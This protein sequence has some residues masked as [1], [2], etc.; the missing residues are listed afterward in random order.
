MWISCS[1]GKWKNENVGHSVPNS[2]QPHGLLPTRFLC[3]RDSPGKNTGVSCHALTQGIFLNQV[4]NLHLLHLLHWQASSLPLAP[5]GSNHWPSRESLGF[6]HH[7]HC[8]MWL[9]VFAPLDFCSV[10]RLGLNVPES[11]SQSHVTRKE[12]ESRH[13]QPQLVYLTPT[14]SCWLPQCPPAPPQKPSPGSDHFRV[15]SAS[16]AKTAQILVFRICNMF[17]LL[18]SQPTPSPHLKIV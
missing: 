16:F 9:K 13:F 17:M 15:G 4:L 3:P 11:A 18:S 8:A 5:S 1:G 10:R 14:T 2:L 7:R 6:G 12:H